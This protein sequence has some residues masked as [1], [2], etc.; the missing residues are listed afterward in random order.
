MNPNQKSGNYKKKKV[1]K[2]KHIRNEKAIRKIAKQEAVKTVKQKT[3]SKFFDREQITT[4]VDYGGLSFDLLADGGGFGI[5]Q[6][7]TVSRYVGSSITPTHIRIRG[8]LGNYGSSDVYNAVRIIV[9]QCKANTYIP[10]GLTLLTFPNSSEAPY[11]PFDYQTN[12][13][14]R[15]LFDEF[16]AL[17]VDTETQV[18]T[19]DIRIT[20]DKL[21]P[22]KLF[23]VGGA[24]GGASY[25]AGGLYLYAVSDSG[26]VAHPNIRFISRVY[27]KDC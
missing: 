10:N 8:L 9:L 2:G 11:S 12:D 21:R 14:Y 3:E 1:Y 7:T 24:S 25:E 19:F 4:A 5:N 13:Q 16:Y 23:G 26:A 6:G 17:V 18:L 15:I 22:I 20:S 27:F